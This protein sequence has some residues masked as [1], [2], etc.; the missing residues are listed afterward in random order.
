[1]CQDEYEKMVERIKTAAEL[2]KDY[3]NFL[4]C[5]DCLSYFDR[6]QAWQCLQDMVNE[7]G[8]LIQT[9]GFLF[10]GQYLVKG[11]SLKQLSDAELQ[12]QILYIGQHIPVYVLLREGDKEAEKRIYQW[13][14]PRQ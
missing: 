8:D 13:L 7:Y 9:H 10:D 4:R 5:R 11:V 6:K 14:K 2:A 1:M 12:A 3:Q